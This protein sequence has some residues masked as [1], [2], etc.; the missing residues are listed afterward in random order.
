MHGANLDNTDTTGEVWRTASQIH[1]WNNVWKGYWAAVVHSGAAK[2]CQPLLP[3]PAAPPQTGSSPAPGCQSPHSS[4]GVCHPGQPNREPEIP[5]A[6]PG[7]PA[8]P[9]ENK[10]QKKGKISDVG[11]VSQLNDASSHII[12]HSRPTC[13][14]TAENF[15]TWRVSS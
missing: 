12:K 10:K 15:M 8:P 1:L 9:R 2:T 14:A 6:C 7:S 5:E 3:H 4:I 13:L 11:E